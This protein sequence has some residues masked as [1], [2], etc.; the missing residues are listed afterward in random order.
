MRVCVHVCMCVC[1]YVCM[2]VCVYVCMCVYVCDSS[3]TTRMNESRRTYEW[4]MSQ[5]QISHVAHMDEPC[6]TLEW[7]YCHTNEPCCTHKYTHTPTHPQTHAQATHVCVWEIQGSRREGVISHMCV[8]YDVFMCVLLLTHTEHDNVHFS[9]WVMS[10]GTIFSECVMSHICVMHDSFMCVPWLT[11]TKQK[12]SSR[13]ELFLW[14]SRVM[15]HSYGTEGFE[16]IGASSIV[17]AP[18]LCFEIRTIS[19]ERTDSYGV[20]HEWVIWNQ[21]KWRIWADRNK[22]YSMCSEIVEVSKM[23]KMSKSQYM[24]DMTH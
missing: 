12:D 20:C 14:V 1:V 15:T 3:Y 13:L 8:T 9:E 22:F 17:C 6:H 4:V 16:Q 10:H 24:W 21:T 23:G 19:I 11:H 7:V 5:I 2:C 18:R